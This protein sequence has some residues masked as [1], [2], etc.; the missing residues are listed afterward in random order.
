MVNMQA[1]GISTSLYVGDTAV[2][3][4]EDDENITVIPLHVVVNLC[5]SCMIVKQL[6]IVCVKVT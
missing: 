3:E 1:L 6:E 4:C 5:C 2:P